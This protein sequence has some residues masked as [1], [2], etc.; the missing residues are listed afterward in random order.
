M[1][2]STFA[3]R[4]KVRDTKPEY[5]KWV[6]G[7][8]AWVTWPTIQILGPLISLELLKVQTSNLARRLIVS[9]TKW[10]KWKIGQKGAWPWSRDLLFIFWDPANISGTA[11]DTNQKFCMHINCNGYW[12]K[13]MKNWPKGGVA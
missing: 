9:D 11:E 7:G 10:K 5:E 3:C 1:Q 4:L 12:K 13:K 8:V 6:N 2:T